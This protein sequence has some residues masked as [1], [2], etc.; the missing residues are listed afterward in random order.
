MR[1]LGTASF[2]K[3][4]QALRAP[5][6][7]P[8]QEGSSRS[9]RLVLTWL[10]RASFDDFHKLPMGFVGFRSIP[11]GLPW[12]LQDVHIPRKYRKYTG[13][14]LYRF[15]VAYMAF[16]GFQTP[17]RRWKSTKSIRKRLPSEVATA[18]P[19]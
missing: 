17:A 7:Q 12:I 1:K 19:R 4:G 18:A 16:T 5:L 13:I 10:R 3:A 2:R 11:M 9:V 15:Y 6:D 8:C 14:D